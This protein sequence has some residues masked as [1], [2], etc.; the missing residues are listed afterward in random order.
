MDVEEM[1]ASG[2]R[3]IT[4]WSATATHRGT[5]RGLAPTGR[6]V[7]TSGIAID[8]VVG[9]RRVEGWAMMDVWGLA[10]QLGG[11]LPW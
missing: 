6:R 11:T 1:L 4:R 5:F 10:R 9:G 3:V 7:R 8:R 2:D